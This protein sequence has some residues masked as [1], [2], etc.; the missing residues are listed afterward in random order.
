MTDVK[1]SLRTEASAGLPVHLDQHTLGRPQLPAEIDDELMTPQGAFPQPENRLSYMVGFCSCVS[2]FPIL[3][4][5]LTRHRTLVN[6]MLGSLSVIE[7]RDAFQWIREADG[8]INYVIDS[9]PAALRPQVPGEEVL[10]PDGV[11]GMQRANLLIT[12]ASV[13]FAL[14][15]LGGHI[16]LPLE[17][18]L[19]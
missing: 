19:S 14:V 10:D 7:R 12:A 17:R 11:Y 3:S 6:R 2:L 8:R 5:I 16:F 4:D 9:L 1:K 15:S 18:F 13:R